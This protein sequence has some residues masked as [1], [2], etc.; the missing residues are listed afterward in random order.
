MWV[1]TIHDDV[2]RPVGLVI[3]EIPAAKSPSKAPARDKAEKM[4]AAL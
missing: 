1:I 2:E 4:R 3:P